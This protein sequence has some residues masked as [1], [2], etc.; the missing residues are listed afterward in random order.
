MPKKA[1]D[2]E[3]VHDGRLKRY[4][5][6]PTPK[7]PW[8][9]K[10][11]VI[12]EDSGQVC[13]DRKG[14][15]TTAQNIRCTRL[16]PGCSWK[17]LRSESTRVSNTLKRDWRHASSSLASERTGSFPVFPLKFLELSGHPVRSTGHRERPSEGGLSVNSLKGHHRQV[18]NVAS[19]RPCWMRLSPRSPWRLYNCMYV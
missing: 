13:R 8:P 17:A 15:N 11:E 16:F 7:G 12:M 9:T 5:P 18:D 1:K 4:V 14:V 10:F 19:G 3:L 6:C 2:L